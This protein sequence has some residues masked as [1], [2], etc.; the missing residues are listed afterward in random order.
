M[1]SN[2]KKIIILLG[3][4]FIA[5]FLIGNTSNSNNK[6]EIQENEIS[7]PEEAWF[8]N[9]QAPIYIGASC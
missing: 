3:L 1:K 2:I 4:I 8:N 5:A 6:D 9:N 7:T